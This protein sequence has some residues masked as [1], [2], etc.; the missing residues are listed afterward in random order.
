VSIIIDE[1]PGRYTSIPPWLRRVL[2]YDFDVSAECAAVLNQWAA[3][4]QAHQFATWQDAIQAAYQTPH[5][6]AVPFDENAAVAATPGLARVA[7]RIVRHLY[8]LTGSSANKLAENVNRMAADSSTLLQAAT[9]IPMSVRRQYDR[10]TPER[11]LQRDVFE[12]DWERDATLILMRHPHLVANQPTI[13]APGTIDPTTMS[14]SSL[15]A[16]KDPQRASAVAQ[17]AAAVGT[18]AVNAEFIANSGH[19]VVETRLEMP[20]PRGPGTIRYHDRQRVLPEQRRY[21]DSF[22]VAAASAAEANDRQHDAEKKIIDTVHHLLMSRCRELNVGPHEVTGTLAIV[23]SI[24]MCP[25][26]YL[27]VLQFL[28]DFPQLQISVCRAT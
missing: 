16:V 5:T 23:T 24:R 27:V 2:W 17:L 1:I 22:A 10:S 7:A 26:C 9:P 21:F 28:V 11:I 13:L 4:G 18:A 19:D 14:A 12:Q 25:S 8:G 6:P 3:D 20:D 15:V